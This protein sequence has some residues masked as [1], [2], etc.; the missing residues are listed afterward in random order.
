[1]IEIKKLPP[2]GAMGAR[3]LQAW[4]QRRNA[5]RSGVPLTRQEKKR[6]RQEKRA[7]ARDQRVPP[8]IAQSARLR[9]LRLRAGRL[10]LHGDGEPLRRWS[11]WRI[12]FE[13]SQ[14]G[15]SGRYARR[16][17]MKVV[18]PIPMPLSGSDT[19]RGFAPHRQICESHFPNFFRQKNFYAVGFCFFQNFMV[20]RWRE[21]G[22]DGNNRRKPRLGGR[23]R[24]AV[25]RAFPPLESIERLAFYRLTLEPPEIGSNQSQRAPGIREQ[26]RHKADK[27]RSGFLPFLTRCTCLIVDALLLQH[28]WRDPR[29]GEE[30]HEAA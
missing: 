23:V 6:Q 13:Q 20:G 7:K 27:D 28:T 2:D 3:D 25:A 14:G 1:M 29:L 12:I 19:C 30:A 11:A 5:G 17:A 22:C 8:A 9:I 16:S 21:G 10:A 4:S 24:G 18:T 15:Q 26:P